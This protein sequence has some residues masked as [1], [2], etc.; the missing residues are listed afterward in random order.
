MGGQSIKGHAVRIS[1][2]FADVQAKLGLLA[3]RPS[4]QIACRYFMLG[5]CRN[6]NACAFSH[7]PVNA[8]TARINCVLID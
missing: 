5:A 1:Q 3:P 2:C 4:S 7:D 8:H 6:G